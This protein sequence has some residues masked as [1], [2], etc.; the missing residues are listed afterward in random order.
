MELQSAVKSIQRNQKENHQTALRPAASTS[1]FARP[2]WQLHQMVGNQAVGRS[3]QAKLKISEPGD[4]HE[5]EADRVA[6]EVMRMPEPG[7]TQ[8]A[9]A[10]EQQ[11]VPQIQRMGTD[12]QEEQAMRMMSEKEEEEEGEQ[13]IQMK[14]VSARSSEASLAVEAS[15]RNGT[16]GGRSLSDST[17]AYFEPRFGHDFSH[18]R[19]HSDQSAAESAH[20]LNARAY[21]IGRNIVFGSGEFAPETSEGRRLLTHELVHVVQQGGAERRSS[22]SPAQ[23]VDRSHKP[24]GNDVHLQSKQGLP[25]FS[26]VANVIQRQDPLKEMEGE[27]PE[28]QPTD[29]ITEACKKPSGSSP[30]VEV[31]KDRYVSI[32]DKPPKMRGPV[33]DTVGCPPTGSGSVFFVSGRPAWDFDIPCSDCVLQPLPGT[34]AKQA[35]ALQIGFIQTVETAWHGGVYFQQSKPGAEWKWAGN[36]WLCVSNARDGHAT[37]T[38]PWYG[39]DASG[40]FGPVPFGQCPRLAD[41]PFVKLPSHQ[42]LPSKNK[43]KPK[44]VPL[45]RMR[46]DGI[47]HIWLIAQAPGN[48]PVFIHNWNIE[49]WVVA[50]L[51]EDAHP[52]SASAWATFDMKSLK[53]SGPG[54]G[55]ATPVLTGGTAN[56]LKSPC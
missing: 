31:A 47:Y 15:D 35:P 56:T 11:Q 18:V 44:K 9:A 29:P 10:T 55:S 48:P 26:S 51:N 23:G 37:S 12:C 49:C 53:S 27:K 19:I 46:I 2:L 21:T 39:P 24:S 16:A 54:I 41:N 7:A 33:V 43:K 28:E 22:A 14:E 50:I 40:N 30:W 42:T 20:S 5:K 13:A 4:V 25:T 1:S 34:K 8:E 32:A 45:R 3:I 52:C 38:A 36:D 17:R 6:D